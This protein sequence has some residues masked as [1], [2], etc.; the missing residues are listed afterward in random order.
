MCS[1]SRHLFLAL[2][3]SAMCCGYLPG[4]VATQAGPIRIK[5]VVVTMFERGEDTGDTPGEFQLWVEREHLDQIL[6]LPAGYHHVR[7]NKDGVLGIVTGVGTAKAA[8][9]V[10]ALGLDP[11]FDLSRRSRLSP[12]LAAEIGRTF[13]LG[14]RSGGTMWSMATW[15]SRSTHV[16]FLRV[17]R[18]DMFHCARAL[19]MTQRANDLYGEMYTL[20]RAPWAGRSTSR[21]TSRWQTPMPCAS[22]AHA[23][24]HFQMP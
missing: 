3:L 4:Q 10:M 18:L 1:R 23:F 9:S 22:R 19:P 21:K 6:P 7:L 12:A 11:R 15:H 13:R 24:R 5:V 8:S 2:A 17:G 20:N 16:K 14:R